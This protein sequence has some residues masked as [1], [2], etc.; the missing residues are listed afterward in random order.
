MLILFSELVFANITINEIMADP[1]DDEDL[2]EWIELFN[3]NSFAVNVSGWVLGGDDD[4]DSIEGGLYNGEGTIIPANGFAIITDDKTRV[5]NNFNVSE[6]AIR[7]YLNDS[8]ITKNGLKNDGGDTVYLYDNNGNLIDK[9]TYNKTKEDLSWAFINGSFFLSEA[10]PGYNNNGSLVIETEDGCDFQVEFLLASDVFD[11]SSA[12]DFRIRASKVK[13]TT[14]N[15]TGRASIKDLF[16]TLI[17]E[18]KPFTN[19]SITRQKTSSTL[20]PNLEEG[21]SYELKANVT[22]QCNDTNQVN[23][24]DTRIVTIKGAPLEKESSLSIESILD[25]GSD[26]K[27]KFGQ[28]IRARV[29][30]YKGDT[31]KNSVALWIEDDKGERL[32]KES[33]INAPE[34]FTSNEFTVPIQI[35][36]NCDK[37]FKDDEYTIKIS[38]LDAEEDEAELEIEGI[39][40]TICRE[41]KVEAKTSAALRGFS[42]EIIEMPK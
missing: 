21:K 42:Y 8:S 27:A 10:T 33:R 39:D 25:L 14:T 11:N 23:N 29:S 9:V 34:K 38:G 35:K 36:P 32:S 30:V 40:T 37:D 17:R 6:N 5:Y 26:K 18:Y 31:T 15:I 22:T 7:L 41:I 19:E 3:N 13:G 1:I 24:F 12:F 4:N 28:T 2:N 16:G 20:T